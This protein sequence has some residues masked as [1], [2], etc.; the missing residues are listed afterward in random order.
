MSSEEER[1]AQSTT[2]GRSDFST[3]LASYAQPGAV[4]LAIGSLVLSITTS[5][6]QSSLS[7]EQTRIAKEQ[8]DMASGAAEPA[9][10]WGYTEGSDKKGLPFITLIVTNREK[11]SVNEV[12]LSVHAG[13]ATSSPIVYNYRFTLLESCSRE[14]RG[15]YRS[16]FD[17]SKDGFSFDLTFR[18]HEGQ[19]WSKSS[20][21]ILEKVDRPNLDAESDQ[22]LSDTKVEYKI[23]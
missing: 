2:T 17:K 23:C 16:D 7:K 21:G 6:E 8:Q 11:W 1:S 15:I 18:D 14:T 10:D 9:V 5:C 13:P 20:D 3:K 19:Y 4:A 22:T 12:T